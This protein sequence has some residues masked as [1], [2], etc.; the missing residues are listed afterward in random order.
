MMRLSFAP[1]FNPMLLQ[2][3]G[4]NEQIATSCSICD[5]RFRPGDTPLILW[6]R[7]EWCVRLCDACVDQWVRVR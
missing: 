5:E 2:W 4:P 1:D 3:L 6:N 7:N